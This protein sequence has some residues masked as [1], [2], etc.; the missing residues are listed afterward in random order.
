MTT[1]VRVAV[2]GA[3]VSGLTAAYD[4]RRLLGSDARIDVFCAESMP[5]GLLAT[6]PLGPVTLDVGAEAFI[7]RRPEAV[8][9]VTELGLADHVVSPGPMRPAIWSGGVLHA[10]PS[11]ALMGIPA[12]ADVVRGLL[13]PHDVGFVESEPSRPFAWSPGADVS[14]GDLV[15]ERFGEHVVARSVDPMLGGVYSARSRDLG[16]RETIPA[17]A[18]ALDNGAP[19]LTA[20][21]AAVIARGT[22]AGPVFGA[23]RGGYRTLVDALIV[24]ARVD[25]HTGV[26]VPR[27]SRVGERY[28]LD[29][30]GEYNAVVVA[31]PVWTAGE[32]LADVAPASASAFAGV[33]AAGSAVVGFAVDGAS[34]LPDNSGVLV[35]SDAD[36]SIKA[37]TLSSRKWPHLASQPGGVSVLR[38]SFGR[39]G[40]PVTGTDS[41][42]VERAAADLQTVFGAAGLPAPRVVDAAVQRWP[43]GLPHYGPGHLSL[44]ADAVAS[45]PDGV[46]V[47]GSGYRGVGVPA[48]IGT[49]RAAAV[50]VVDHLR[51]GG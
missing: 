46:A 47:A 10:L 3:G 34:P 40:E 29:G 35:A 13:D 5:G 4:L 15:A 50:R 38:A 44:M 42:L 19:S 6:R 51:G 32:L 14:V 36:L 12:S 30:I 37:I 7:V 48:C 2:V 33:R 9:L 22:G 28:R 21:V 17:L 41:E 8:E 16:L 45:L 23:L 26:A 39:L 25:V 27:V 18:T 24:A 1:D 20:A 11:P 49:G 31:T 43:G